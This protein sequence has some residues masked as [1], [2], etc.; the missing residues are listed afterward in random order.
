VGLSTEDGESF[1][2]TSFN[3]W[4]VNAWR[5]EYVDLQ[6]GPSWKRVNIPI[7]PIHTIIPPGAKTD[8]SLDLKKEKFRQNNCRTLTE[9]EYD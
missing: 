8:A 7:L 2:Q 3:G 9:V 6:K 1:I 4:D 5:R